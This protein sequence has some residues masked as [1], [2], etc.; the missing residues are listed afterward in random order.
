MN[1][2][3]FAFCFFR[4]SRLLLAVVC[5]LSYFNNVALGHL[6]L[7]TQ[8]IILPDSIRFDSNSRV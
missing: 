8:L 6:V 1:E 3:L 5:C 4:R 2:V 7:S